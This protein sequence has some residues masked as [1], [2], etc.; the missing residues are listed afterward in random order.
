MKWQFTPT[1][2]P[3][4]N[5]ISESLIKSVKR[6]ITEATGENVMTFS[7]LITVFKMEFSITIE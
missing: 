3:W 5:G 6:A 4:Q 1:N 7:E 2:A